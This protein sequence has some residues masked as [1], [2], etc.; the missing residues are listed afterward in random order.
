[1]KKEDFQEFFKL[2]MTE[3]LHKD[4]L[5]SYRVKANNVMSL[6]IEFRGVLENWTLGN[7]KNYQTVSYCL[8]ECTDLIKKDT[9]LDFSFY[10]KDLFIEEFSIYDKEQRADKNILVSATMKLKTYVE[11]CISIN[12]TIYL[13]RLLE[14]I[15]KQLFFE[16][17]IDDTNFSPTLR[18]FDAYVSSFACELL[19]KGFSKKY[20][21]S[22]FKYFKQ[23]KYRIPFSEAFD[24][25]CSTLVFGEKKRYTVVFKLNFP[26]DV[27]TDT[28]ITD[29]PNLKASIDESMK[30]SIIKEIGY[31]EEGDR[32]R[33]YIMEIDALDSAMAA[34]LCHD[35][36]STIFDF[37]LNTFKSVEVPSTAL[38]FCPRDGIDGYNV[39]LE[40]VF[41]LDRGDMGMSEDEHSLYEKLKSIEQNPIISQDVKDRIIAA[42]R[43]LRIGDCQSE[44]EQQFINYWIA[45]EFIFASS[46]SKESTFDRIKKFFIEISQACYIKRNILYLNI[47]LIKTHRIQEDEYYWEK[48]DVNEFINS[49]DNILLK[50]RLLNMKS[51]LRNGESIKK[52]LA[53][54]RKNI[55]QHITRIYRLR[56]ELIHEAAIKQDIA[57]VTSNLRSYLVFVLNQLIFYFNSSNYDMKSREMMQFFLTYESALK[58]NSKYS[59]INKIIK[60][61][62]ENNPIY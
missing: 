27:S 42:I 5:D 10:D 41:I 34:R 28:T 47:W 52:Y 40:K 59:D 16:G 29:F 36:L 35:E 51:H 57:N 1:M 33:F 7:I 8:E 50:Y 56:N 39:K 32:I 49:I 43:H 37:N 54:H 30:N 14:E 3:I 13:K 53:Q 20:L 25:M 55:E 31:K 48:N 19:R 58:I 9:C 15:R 24:K 62:L 60:T 44:I 12:K 18:E 61:P 4:T 21:Y 23:N 22:F 46:L 11:M 45:L 2:R 17:T 6:L 26:H 38:T